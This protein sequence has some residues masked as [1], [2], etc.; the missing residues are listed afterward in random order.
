ML[1]WKIYNFR[2]TANLMKPIVLWI[3]PVLIFFNSCEQRAEYGSDY[4]SVF[5]KSIIT[6]MEF[7]LFKLEKE[8]IFLKDQFEFLL[9]N[10]DS[11]LKHADKDKYTFDGGYSVNTPKDSGK[12][13]SIVILNTTPDFEEAMDNVLISNSMDSIFAHIFQENDMLSQV[14]SNS[15]DQVS[16]VFPAYDAKTLLDPDIDLTSFNFF[17]EGDLHHNP[18]KGP[19]WIPEI[20][21]DPAGRGWILSLVHPVLDDGK[22]HAVLGIDIT[23]DELISRFLE[24]RDGH[25]LIVNGKGDI[26]GGKASA[27]KAL[28][29]PP[30]LN[31]VYLE[32]IL[33][34]NFRISDFNL[35]NSKNQEVR[36]MAH[37]IIQK[38]ESDF[39][40]EDEF[41]PTAAYAAPFTLLD[42]YLI[43][44]IP[45][46]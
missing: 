19:V 10:R 2:F 20:Y 13:S 5:D 25:F 22:L 41:S 39:I 6:E 17:Y 45:S 44:I 21:V 3:L 40:F 46:S 15:V 8:I 27:I 36:E 26:V 34:D 1:R 30:L 16:R 42:W 31:H 32:T 38:K 14:Y 7:E 43:E 11:L 33:A 4:D 29:F 18:E 23:V 9:A 28:S 12:L 24:K 35:Y 37:S